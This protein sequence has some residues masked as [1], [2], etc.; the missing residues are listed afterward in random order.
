MSNHPINLALRFSL[1]LIALGTVGSW[2]YMQSETWTKW[3]FALG[4]PVLFMT[5][6]SVF[7][8]PNDPSR[9]GKAPIPTN[10]I[11]RLIIEWSLFGLASWAFFDGG[12]Y[13][14]ILFAC[15]V[16]LHYLLSFDRIRWLWNQ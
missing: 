13:Y 4:L 2:G 8:V 6:W 1:E 11:L 7:A 3:L 5:I 15:M 12:S 9:S 16:I 14:A 10:G